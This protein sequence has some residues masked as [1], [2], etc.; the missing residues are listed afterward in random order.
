VLTARSLPEV[1]IHRFRSGEAEPR[2]EAIVGEKAHHLM[3]A[4]RLN[5]AV[6]PGFVLPVDVARAFHDAGE[7]LPAGAMERVRREVHGLESATGRRFGDPE[8]PLLL[9]VR[10][11]AAASMPGMLDTVLNVGLTADVAKAWKLES[12]EFALDCEA[13]LLAQVGNVV[14]RFP[15]DPDTGQDAF[16][17]ARQAAERDAGGRL[18]VEGRK[19]LVA[20]YRE[21]LAPHRWP[22]DAWAQLESAIGAIFRSWNNPRALGY[23]RQHGIDGALGT[24]VIV[25]A[26]VF[27]N[28][29]EQS[30]TGVALTRDPSSGERRFCG[31]YLVR[32]QGDDVMSG[33]HTPMALDGDR[34]P[35]AERFPEAHRQLVEMRDRLERHF[36]DLLEL[37]FTVESGTLWLLQ[38]KAARRSPTAA[39]RVAVDM[40]DE[41]LL[42]ESDA[43][44]RV[45]TDDV[46]DLLEPR[47]DPNADA[48]VVARGLPACPGATSGKVV[49]SA[50]EAIRLGAREPV[51]LVRVETSP[52]DVE[53]MKA[54][55]GVLTARGGMTSHAAVVARGLGRPCVVGCAELSIDGSRKVFRVA[56]DSEVSEGQVITIDGGTGDVLLGPM[57]TVR[58]AANEAFERLMSW[59]DRHRRLQVRA[60]ADTVDEARVACRLGAEGIGLCRTE[61]MFGETSRRRALQAMLLA[62]SEVGRRAAIKRMEPLQRDDFLEL[63][64]AMPGLPVVIRLLDPAAH[65]WRP[66]DEG[67]L[68]EVAAMMGRAVDVVRA[69][70]DRQF[71]QNPLLGLRGSRL[72]VAHPE[73]YEA[74]TRAALTA[75]VEVRRRGIDVRPELMLPLITSSRELSFLRQRLL[76]VAEKVFAEADS[77][78]EFHIG[79][80]IEVPRAA[81]RAG[82]LARSAEFFSFGTNDLT[83]LTYGISRED[84]QTIV[85]RY[86]DLG[87]LPADPFAVLDTEGVGALLEIAVQR[88]RAA[89][90]G[91][92][93]GL[94][95]RHA[96]DARSIRFAHRIGL[97]YV[98]CAPHRVPQARLAAAQAAIREG[99]TA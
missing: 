20:R 37:E 30:A 76:A 29:D 71:D 3:E 5:L 42:R 38:V 48:K 80:M 68:E 89:R 32:A 43:L 34:D 7:R 66:R 81:L 69:K 2:S 93:F 82:E 62:E 54:A 4:C 26:M 95:G 44:L 74:Q 10:S 97:D 19:A 67:E 59:A 83:M 63:Y 52:E 87:L 22:E 14:F 77:H 70:V 86:L 27:G 51:I 49:F 64:E 8:A 85:P 40:V 35:F 18:T 33:A 1:E 56:G 65:L 90:D 39:F 99:A 91:L 12:P 46:E 60:N 72:G 75:A 88:G 55:A 25:Q 47:L 11:G 84:V 15:H 96:G 73:L 45:S 58:Q 21:L 24:A 6:P 16:D 13:R 50:R 17:E 53:A 57:Q 9:S 36:R 78:V 61:G 98:S 23:R 31:E 79:T 94:T 41:G 92:I 28:R